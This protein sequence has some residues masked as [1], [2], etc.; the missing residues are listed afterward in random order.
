MG[1]I[2]ISL[3]LLLFLF[4]TQTLNLAENN[5]LMQGTDYLAFAEKMPEPVGGLKAI[6]EKITYPEIAKRAGVQGKVYV[7]AFI[8][9]N[10]GVDDVKV[11][12]GIGGGCD[13]AAVD[14]VKSSKFSPGVSEGKPARVKM[15]L[16][17]QF[18]L[19]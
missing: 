19:S 12:K 15:S 1:K 8:N 2:K 5:Y 9:E 18:K 6:Y 14:A 7:L 10:G 3:L 4:L 11:V 17:I 13:E 16:Q